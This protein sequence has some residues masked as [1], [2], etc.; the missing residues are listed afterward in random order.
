MEERRRFVRLDTPAEVGYA[1]LPDGSAQ[2]ATAKNISGG[3]LCLAT[4]RPLPSGGQL[5]IAVQL[6]DREQPV[7]AIAEPVWS[8]E[9]EVIGKT[10]RRRSV[11]TGVRFTEIA[12]Q[13]RQALWEF[14]ARTLQTIQ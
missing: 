12:P 6:P 10:E 7:N 14:V 11:A 13:D 9:F 3:G 4:E 5:Q 1:V 8:E 2:R